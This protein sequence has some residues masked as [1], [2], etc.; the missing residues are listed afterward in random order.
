MVHSFAASFIY[1]L[2]QVSLNYPPLGCLFTNVVIGDS[3]NE[4]LEYTAFTKAFAVVQGI[5]LAIFVVVYTVVIYKKRVSSTAQ[6]AEWA[7]YLGMK[8]HN[9]NR[10]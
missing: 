6:D 4:N 8:L 5:V 7:R 3:E 1:L 2:I 9:H 10:Q